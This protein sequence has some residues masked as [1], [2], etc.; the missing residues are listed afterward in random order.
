MA[1]RERRKIGLQS[2][3]FLALLFSRATLI[4][5]IFFISIFLYFHL[6][7]P[8]ILKERLQRR[9]PFLYTQ[10]RF[11]PKFFNLCRRQTITVILPGVIVCL[12]HKLKFAK[13]LH[14]FILR[15]LGAFSC[16]I[17]CRQSQLQT[18]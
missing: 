9:E 10:L 17:C 16:I 12:W 8:F 14:N 1:R 3:H 4:I 2:S 15:L 7:A 18:F 5:I 6:F 13:N 11:W